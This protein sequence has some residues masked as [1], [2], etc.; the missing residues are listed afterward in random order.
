MLFTRHNF[1]GE[2]RSGSCYDQG[3]RWNNI[4]TKRTS[5]EMRECVREKG[6]GSREKEAEEEREMDLRF[7][8]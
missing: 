5:F 2:V 8:I 6:E 4:E 7:R 1:T 3:E